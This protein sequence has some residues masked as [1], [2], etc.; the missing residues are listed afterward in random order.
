MDK[1]MVEIDVYFFVGTIKDW[2]IQ[3]Y[4]CQFFTPLFF[5]Y[6]FTYPKINKTHKNIKNL[7]KRLVLKKIVKTLYLYSILTRQQ[8]MLPQGNRY[9]RV[10]WPKETHFFRLLLL[11]SSSVYS[12]P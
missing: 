2:E 8:H 3:N 12:T 7:G 4:F 6:T 10:N 5:L 9:K 11:L 1:N